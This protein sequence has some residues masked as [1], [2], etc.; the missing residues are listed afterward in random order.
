MKKMML[1]VAT[2]GAVFLYGCKTNADDPKAVLEQFFDALSK[3]DVAKARLLATEESKGMIDLM[4]MGLKQD[5]ANESMK[6]DKN[7]MKFGEVKIDGD[8]AVIPVTETKSGELINYALKKEGGK[9]KV[10]FDKATLMNI[11]MEKMKEKN[12]NINPGDSLNNAM[13]ELKNINMDSLKQG[14]EKSMKA[15]DSMN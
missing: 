1:V 14:M 3:K 6:Y 2:I 4:E 9:W 5:T 15:M 11:G 13:E 7:T 12:I 10:A 8:K